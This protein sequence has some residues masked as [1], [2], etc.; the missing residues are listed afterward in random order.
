MDDVTRKMTQTT[1]QETSAFGLGLER[2]RD[3]RSPI[4]I[5]AGK[6]HPSIST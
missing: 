6:S 4:A 2:A 3:M 1:H 5:I